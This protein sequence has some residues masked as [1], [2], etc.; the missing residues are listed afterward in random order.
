MGEWAYITPQH[1][2]EKMEIYLYWQ[3]LSF[4]LSAT[5]LYVLRNFI[6]FDRKMA[7]F[8]LQEMLR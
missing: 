2:N 8:C 3:K 1:K 5:S 4:L 7:V 6:Y